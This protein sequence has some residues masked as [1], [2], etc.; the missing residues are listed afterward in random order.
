MYVEPLIGPETVN[1]LP[2]DTLDAYRDHGSPAA[3]LGQDLDEARRVLDVLPKLGIDLAEVA[4]RLEDE[5]IQ[6]FGDPFDR[7][8]DSLEKH[9]AAAV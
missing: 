1:T 6:K 2:L 7:L 3:R 5:G 4:R 9:R 8:L